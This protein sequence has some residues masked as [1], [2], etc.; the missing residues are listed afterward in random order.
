MLLRFSAVDSLTHIK[1]HIDEFIA[2]KIRVLQVMLKVTL[3]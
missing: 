1:E 3:T 2:I